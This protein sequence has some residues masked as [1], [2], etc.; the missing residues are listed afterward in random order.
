MERGRAGAWVLAFL[1]AAVFPPLAWGGD[2]EIAPPENDLPALSALSSMS[3]HRNGKPRDPVN[4]VLLG[5]RE[6]VARCL[7]RSGWVPAKPHRLRGVVQEIACILEHRSDP[8]A[9][10]SHSYLFRRREDLAFEVE[11]GGSPKKRHH[12]RLWEAPFR[13]RGEEVWEGAATFDNG[14]RAAHL[15]HRVDEYIDGERDFLVESLRDSGSL[16]LLRYL[17]GWDSAYLKNRCGFIS[18]GK[19]A[20]VLLAGDRTAAGK[21]RKPR[22]SGGNGNPR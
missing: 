14:L 3:L 5:D 16:R 11:V 22:D 12:V 6:S 7:I 9:P 19:V 8:R 18:D 21:H 20:M 2:V 4:V 15:D 13:L 17:P 1:L 10:V